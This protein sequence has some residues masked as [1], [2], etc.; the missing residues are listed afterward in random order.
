MRAGTRAAYV[1]APDWDV[2]LRKGHH[3]GLISLETFQTVQR[4]MKETPPDH[5]LGAVGGI[6]LAPAFL[7]EGDIAAATV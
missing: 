1:E 3:E 6:A 5:A 4:R 2:S 7:K